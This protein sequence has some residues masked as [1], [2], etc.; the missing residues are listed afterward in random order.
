MGAK[1]DIS[2]TVLGRPTAARNTHPL[3]ILLRKSPVGALSLLILVCV[4]CVAVLAPVLAP[5]DPL[6]TNMS[7][8]RQPPSAAH[9]LGT[10]HLGRDALSR[11]IY[12]TRITL[13]VVLSSV[14]IGDGIG[15]IWGL[16]SGYI[17]GRFDLLGQRLLD[18]KMAFPSLILAMLLLAGLGS[19]LPTV[20]IAIAITR[21]PLTTRTIRSV[22]L[23]IKQMPY[24]EAAESIGATKWRIATRHIM[25][26]CIAP[27]LVVVSFSLGTAI[28]TEAALSF[29]GVGVP[30]PAPSWGS[31]L[32]GVLADSFKPQWWLV[33]FPGLAITITITAANLLGD[34]LRDLLDPR[35]R[36]RM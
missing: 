12:G 21:I 16:A 18:V 5:Y 28:F 19:G 4:V 8:A 3:R 26:Q 11:L 15:F 25:P 6:S 13:V 36:Q 33:L 2:L 29:L 14:L 34:A 7:V 10:D 27:L 24:V 32:S 22:V 9:W 30:P 35:L 23:S 1:A 31:M 17:G 20:I